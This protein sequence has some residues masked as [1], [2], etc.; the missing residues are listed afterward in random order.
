MCGLFS[1]V[2]QCSL[3]LKYILA[4]LQYVPVL[5]IPLTLHFVYQEA[6]IDDKK[7][8]EKP[9]DSGKIAPLGPAGPGSD[10]NPHSLADIDSIQVITRIVFSEIETLD[11]V[12]YPDLLS[13][14]WYL[15]VIF[16]SSSCSRSSLLY[17]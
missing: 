3:E 8:S 9:A 12:T 15:Q 10:V 7:D 14:S 6:P 16:K 11:A 5:P 4:N 17:K 1:K 13:Q 2:E